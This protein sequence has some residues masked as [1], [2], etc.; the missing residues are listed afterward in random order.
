MKNQKAKTMVDAYV[1]VHYGNDGKSRLPFYM[2]HNCMFTSDFFNR[3]VMIC[4]NKK[5]AEIV[6]KGLEE[7][8]ANMKHPL[9]GQLKVMQIGLFEVQ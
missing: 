2:K 6:R 5:D 7:K 4:S 1:I 3:E 9:E 8:I